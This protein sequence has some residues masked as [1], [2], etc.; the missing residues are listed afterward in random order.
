MKGFLTSEQNEFDRHFRNLAALLGYTVCRSAPFA[1]VIPGDDNARGD[2]FL[3]AMAWESGEF[4]LPL[5]RAAKSIKAGE[6]RNRA[7]GLCELIVPA[8]DE[9]LT[10]ERDRLREALTDAE[11]VIDLMSDVVTY[12]A[13]MQGPKVMGINGSAAR[14]AAEAARKYLIDRSAKP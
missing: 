12:D 9:V 4:S 6:W 2:G 13:T 14:R 3:D 8:P 10:A 1:W 5:Y 7:D 11:R